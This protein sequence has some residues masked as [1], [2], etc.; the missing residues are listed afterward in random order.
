MQKLAAAVLAAGALFAGQPYDFTAVDKV[1]ETSLA[2]LNGGASLLLIKDG[3]VIYRKAY[4]KFTVEE[5]V[6]IAS[7]SKWL[8]A[9]A[10]MRLAEKRTLSLDDT[11]GK[12]IPDAPADKRPITVRQMFSHMAGFQFATPCMDN[13][14]SMTLANCAVAILELKLLD[15]PGASFGYSGAG[16]MLGGRVAEVAADKPWNTI[17]A[18][19]VAGPLGMK[20][21][22]FEE[23][24]PR[25]PGVA[26]SNIDDY[27]KLLAMILA[28]GKVGGK[29]YLSHASLVEMR[30]DQT[31]GAPIRSSPGVGV[32]KAHRYGLGQWIEEKDSSGASIELSSPGAFGTTP[33]VDLKRNLGGV[34]LVSSSYQ[35]V[36]PVYMKL[37]DAVRRAV[38]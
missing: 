10:I 2:T 22:H 20:A 19:E 11:V 37:K 32:A 15:A 28:D 23:K 1:I 8:S 4:G 31:H 18:E 26:V 24:N 38:D 12:F 30:T 6:P 25:V 9:T 35:K 14:T 27:G 17:F 21:T 5:T 29:Q 33:W 7:A 36:A 3:K 34:L 16:M 13:H